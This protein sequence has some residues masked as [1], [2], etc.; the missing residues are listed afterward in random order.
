VMATLSGVVVD[1]G[2]GLTTSVFSTVVVVSG[3]A[4]SLCAA[5]GLQNSRN[6]ANLGST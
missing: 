6:T 1:C 2:T 4:T 5:D 3:P